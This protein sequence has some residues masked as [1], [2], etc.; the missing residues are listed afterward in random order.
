MATFHQ[1]TQFPHRNRVSLDLL[2]IRA[3]VKMELLSP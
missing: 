2:I 3:V 1:L